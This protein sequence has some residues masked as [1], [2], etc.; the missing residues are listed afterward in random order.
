MNALLLPSVFFSAVLLLGCSRTSPVADAV[1]PGV[2]RVVKEVAI[3]SGEPVTTADLSI[4]GM[5]CE[6]MCGGAIKKAL[7]SLGVTGTEIKMSV[8]EGPDHAIVTYDDSKVSDA[9]LVEAIQKLYDGQY[10]VLAI[11]ITKE[12]KGS[13]T[14]NSEAQKEQRDGEVSVVVPKELVVPSILALLSRILGE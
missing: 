1:V 9:Q 6:M 14:S 10:K 3:T 12:V 8:T 2:D 5:S 4:D 11:T 13:T 7:A